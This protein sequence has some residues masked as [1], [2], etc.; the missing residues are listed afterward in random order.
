MKMKD[1]EKQMYFNPIQDRGG[2]GGGGG[3]GA[4]PLPLVEKLQ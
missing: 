3:G 1:S 2:G 4:I